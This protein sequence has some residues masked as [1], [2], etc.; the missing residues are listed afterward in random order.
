MVYNPAMGL[1][2]WICLLT[3]CSGFVWADNWPQWRG[4]RMDGVSRDKGVPVKW[5]PEENITWKLAM[6]SRSGATPIIWGDVIFLNVA[7]EGKL[8]LWAVDRNKGGVLW[9]KHLSDGDHMMRK[10]N[11]SSPSPVTDGKLVV[12]Y[13]KSGT[14]ACFDFDGNEQ[15]KTN[16]Q[17][18]FGKDT[19]WWDLGTSP[20]L[21]GGTHT[22]HGIQG[23]GAGFV[24]SIL[25]RSVL[26][27]IVEITD[28]QA[29]DFARR[30]AKEEGVM[31]GISSGAT[32][33]AIFNTLATLGGKQRVL[34][35]NYDTGERYLSIDGLYPA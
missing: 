31:V 30:S 10:Q 22:P 8:F 18:R 24:P 5:G 34:G 17:E 21:S 16:L 9:K 2:H 26:D 27:G 11:M 20:V 14:L 25:D 15:W 19:L 1:K 7:E 4:P 12:V 6:P 32:L 23:I 3:V 28:E 13:F 35:F 33:A 29:K